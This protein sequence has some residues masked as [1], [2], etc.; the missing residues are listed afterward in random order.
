MYPQSVS[1]PHSILI[2]KLPLIGDQLV[3]KRKGEKYKRVKCSTLAKLMTE[4]NYEESI[5]NLNDAMSQ[6]GVNE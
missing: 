1:I 4:S 3:A 5:Y 6:M 2:F